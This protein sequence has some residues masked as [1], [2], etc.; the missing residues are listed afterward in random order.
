MKTN[1]GLVR[2]IQ[3]VTDMSLGSLSD[4]DRDLAQSVEDAQRETSIHT[5]GPWRARLDEC[6]DTEGTYIITGPAFD[7]LTN[8]TPNVRL[9]A[10]A[11]DL[12]E[13]AINALGALI[14]RRDKTIHVRYDPIEMLEA[15]IAKA[16][17]R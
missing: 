4:Y 2:A 6:N 7:H 13:A 9:I 1:L 11:P 15:A 16:E 14:D 8:H 12:L 17:G 10:A 3:E 5:P